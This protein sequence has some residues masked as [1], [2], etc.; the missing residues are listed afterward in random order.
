MDAVFLTCC[1]R[2]MEVTRHYTPDLGA[3]VAL[4]LAFAVLVAG[5]VLI[6]SPLLM[7]RK[8]R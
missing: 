7:S 5:V 4:M 8:A 1:I 2:G 3:T 6:S